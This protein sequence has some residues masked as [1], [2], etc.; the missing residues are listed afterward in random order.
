LSEPEVYTARCRCGKVELEAVGPHLAHIS[1]YCD[2]CQVAA[3]LID[4]L[5]GGH[6]GIEPDGGTPNLMMRRDRVRIRGGREL[7]VGYH[8]R[9]SSATTRWVA[10]CCNTAITQSHATWWPHRGI[11]SGLFVT[12][13]PPLE[14]RV[15]AR[16]AP[17]PRAIPDDVPRS[18]GTPPR[19]GARLLRA[20]LALRFARSDAG[21]PPGQ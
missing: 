10:S 15:F 13:V 14:M 8:A 19:L 7:L 11:K 9:P 16:Y 17:D 5:E 1:C 20:A 21:P 3:A 2:D 12:P 18:R 6:S 4:A